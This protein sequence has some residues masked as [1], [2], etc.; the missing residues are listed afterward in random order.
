MSDDLGMPKKFFIR[1][2]DS[3]LCISKELL[4]F[5]LSKLVKPIR[6][7]YTDHVT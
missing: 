1:I 4:L 2:F 6:C 5:Y 7:A 3:F